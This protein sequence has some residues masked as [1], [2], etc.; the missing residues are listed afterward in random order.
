MKGSRRLTS[1]LAKPDSRFHRRDH[2]VVLN[3]QMSRPQAQPLLAA[4]SAGHWEACEEI[5]KKE[6]SSLEVCDLE[7]RTALILAAK[8]G[9]AK[10]CEVLISF[11]ADVEATDMYDKTPLAYAAASQY[12]EIASLLLDHGAE[13]E[14][15]DCIV[16]DMGCY[17]L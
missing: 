15:T 17:I 11:R 5:L 10:V 6:P 12:T 4:A 13:V 1:T 3:P 2:Q 14:A 7:G 16:R 9:H 8:S